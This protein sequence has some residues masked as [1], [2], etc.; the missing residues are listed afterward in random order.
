MKTTPFLDYIVY[1]ILGHFGPVTFRPMM[2]GYVLY[3][4]GTVFALVE[5]EGLY[6]KGSKKLAPWYEERGGG[7]FTYIKEG[8]DAYLYYFSVPTDIFEDR[9]KLSEWF[10]I[11]LSAKELK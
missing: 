11:A 4:E 3:F 7:L 5:N 1:D 2:G 9:E 6:F 10:D 8:K